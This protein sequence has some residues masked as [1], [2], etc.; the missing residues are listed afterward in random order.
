MKNSRRSMISRVGSLR[1]IANRR[2]P[3]SGTGATA[4][5]PI[6]GAWGLGRGAKRAECAKALLRP[7]RV[8][9]EALL[10]DRLPTAPCQSDSRDQRGS[11]ISALPHVR[12]KTPELS[13]RGFCF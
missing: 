13:L 9:D 4:L 11:G 10:A 8:A 5:A 7:P 12:K 2:S 1:P 6:W 3:I